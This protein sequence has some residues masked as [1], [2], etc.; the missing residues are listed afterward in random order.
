MG[1][2]AVGDASDDTVNSLT[3]IY[4]NHGREDL[5]KFAVSKYVTLLLISNV[6]DAW[7]VRARSML[8]ANP[9]WQGWVTEFEVITMIRNKNAEVIFYNAECKPEIWKNGVDGHK[10][11]V[12]FADHLDEFFKTKLG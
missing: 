2:G 3:A 4:Q 5:E 10:L 11:I 7:V 9:V 1:A 12:R 6:A 8:R